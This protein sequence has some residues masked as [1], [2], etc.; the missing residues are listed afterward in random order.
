MYMYAQTG[1]FSYIG[2]N[3]C[4]EITNPSNKKKTL[5]FSKLGKILADDILKYFA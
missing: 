2:Q 5:C 4:Q 3:S 1:C